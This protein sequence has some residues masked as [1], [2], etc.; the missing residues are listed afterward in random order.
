[1]IID[2]WGAVFAYFAVEKKGVHHGGTEHTEN[3]P[4][5]CNIKKLSL[6][7]LCVSVVRSV[8][9]SAEIGVDPSAA[10]RACPEPAER[11]GVCG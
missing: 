11:D 3:A 5:P 4:D 2:D 1:L 10:L 8:F 6:S 7:A 9:E